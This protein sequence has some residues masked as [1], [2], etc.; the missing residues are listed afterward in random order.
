[1]HIGRINKC[2]QKDLSFCDFLSFSDKN[3]KGRKIDLDFKQYGALI[4]EGMTITIDENNEAVYKYLLANVLDHY[5]SVNYAGS[6]IKNRGLDWNHTLYSNDKEQENSAT[7]PMLCGLTCLYDSNEYASIATSIITNHNLAR[8]SEQI[9]GNLK[10][11]IYNQQLSEHFNRSIAH[12]G[13][14]FEYIMSDSD[15]KKAPVLEKR[16][17][18]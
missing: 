13:T 16:K 18:N 9:I 10:K 12:S 4:Q 15:S 3:V 1:M 7:V 2:A 14:Q 5:L 11:A 6:T 8:S 17:N